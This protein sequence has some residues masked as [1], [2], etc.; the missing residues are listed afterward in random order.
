VA[1]VFVQQ[2]H[3]ISNIGDKTFLLPIFGAASV[4]YVYFLGYKKHAFLLALSGLA[5]V[6]AYFL[7]LVF[8]QPRPVTFTSV[9]SIPLDVYSFPSSHT[10]TYTVFFG[11]LIF[12][13]LKLPEIPGICRIIGVLVSAYFI[14]FVGVSRVYLGQHYVWD[15]AAGYVFGTL[16]LV[17]IFLLEKHL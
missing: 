1:G 17:G 14:A 12:L 7:K 11:Y 2:M 13:F 4:I 5:V 6:F 8:K 3:F 15:V 10:L 16:Y 9:I